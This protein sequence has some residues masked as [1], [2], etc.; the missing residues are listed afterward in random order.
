MTRALTLP[1]NCYYLDD[2]ALLQRDAAQ[3]LSEVF[4]VKGDS[5]KAYRFMSR[6]KYLDD[7]VLNDEVNKFVLLPGK[8]TNLDEPAPDFENEKQTTPNSSSGLFSDEKVNLIIIGAL[9]LICAFLT[10]VIIR[11]KNETPNS[12]RDELEKINIEGESEPA[13]KEVTDKT[14]EET[15]EKRQAESQPAEQVFANAEA[16]ERF[17]ALEYQLLEQQ[18]VTQETQSELL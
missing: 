2:M 17:K 1:I 13:A 18:R 3:T 9:F 8:Q 5:S 14:S 16:D 10:I 15:Q 4:L 12:E 6:V 7:S 11:R